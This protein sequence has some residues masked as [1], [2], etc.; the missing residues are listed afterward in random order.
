MVKHKTE[1]SEKSYIYWVDRSNLYDFLRTYFWNP[2]WTGDMT[3]LETSFKTYFF[4]I[5]WMKQMQQTEIV[6]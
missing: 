1:I 6:T 5:M 2:V 3:T 4:I